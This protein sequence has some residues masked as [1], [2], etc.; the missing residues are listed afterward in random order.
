MSVSVPV[1]RWSDERRDALADLVRA[2]ADRLSQ[3]LGF[4]P[5]RAG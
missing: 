4:R 1:T 5:S 3:S 2:G